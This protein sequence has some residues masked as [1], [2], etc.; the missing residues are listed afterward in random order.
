MEE[1]KELRPWDIFNKNIKKVSEE[2]KTKRLS[3]CHQCEHF[4]KITSQCKKCGCFMSNKSSIPNAECPIGK[5]KSVT[6]EKEEK[7][8]E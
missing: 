4:M 8:N 7:I 3:I 2:E 1:K 6:I 5:W